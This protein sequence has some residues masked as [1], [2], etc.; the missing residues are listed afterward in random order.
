MLLYVINK[1]ENAVPWL[2][3]EGMAKLEWQAGL[4]KEEPMGQDWLVFR[5]LLVW[6]SLRTETNPIPS[7]LQGCSTP[8]VP[9]LFITRDQFH[10]RQFFHGPGF[11]A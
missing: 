9:N 11:L 6:I 3:S 5:P 1:K 10:G 8:A 4:Q 2:F 7:L